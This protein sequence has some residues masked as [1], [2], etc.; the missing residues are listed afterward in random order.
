[1]NA[2]S[3]SIFQAAMQLPEGE[4]ARLAGRLIKSLESEAD[5]DWEAAWGAEIER[6]VGEIERGEAVTVSWPELRQKLW[7]GLHEQADSA[8]SHGSG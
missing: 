2:N 6:R 7:E 8:H 1:M 3:E 5:D 4:R